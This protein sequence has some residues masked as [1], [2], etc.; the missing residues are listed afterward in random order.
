MSTRNEQSKDILEILSE[1][2]LVQKALEKAARQA[3]QEHKEEGLPLA[4]WRD[5]RV[6]WMTA[7]ELEAESD[8]MADA[9]SSRRDDRV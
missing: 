7:E 2:A 6:V 4:M 5:G 9:S 8:V 3:I 1:G